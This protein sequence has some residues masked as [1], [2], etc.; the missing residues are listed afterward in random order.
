MPL[1]QVTI[2]RGRTPEQLHALGQALTDAAEQ[3]IGAPRASIRVVL[4]ECE[5]EHWFVGGNTLAELRAS[6][7]R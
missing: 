4:T 6:G 3:S 5:P 1:I 2:G 7:Q